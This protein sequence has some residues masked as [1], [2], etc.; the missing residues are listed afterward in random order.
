MTYEGLRLKILKIKRVKFAEHRKKKLKVTDFTIISNNCWGGMVYESYNLKKSSP[1]VG[2]F[3]MSE[4]YI[5]FVSDLRKY[6]SMDIEFIEPT[7]SKHY[8][9][10]RNNPRYGDFPVGKI[11]D[12]EIFFLHY[13]SNQEAADKWKRRCERINWDRLLVKFNDQN[14]CTKAEVQKFLELPLKNKIFFTCIDWGIESEIVLKIK[15]FPKKNHI[16]ASFEPF[17][18][19]KYIDITKLLNNL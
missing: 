1:T 18:K 14:G 10:F 12:I 15:Q 16:M 19:G 6:T 17:G 4:D 5:K 11:D 8:D 13:H 3:F 7:K 9:Y 2:V